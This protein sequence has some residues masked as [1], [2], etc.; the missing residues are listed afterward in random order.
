[1]ST[2]VKAII[3]NS[4]IVSA[5]ESKAIVNRA[6]KIH[7]LSPIATVAVGRALTMAA[8]MGKELKNECDYLT[9]VIDG[10]GPLGKI[11]VCA[12]ASGHVKCDV[13]NPSLESIFKFDGTLDVG[14]AVGKSG[15]LTV[16]KD[17]GLKQP[18]VG[19]AK[20]VSG[21][22]ASD[23][24]YY[25]AASEQQ[26]CGITLGVGLTNKQRCK[27]AGG[28]FVQIMPNCPQEL[29][30]R[31]ETI[32]Y[33]MDEMSYQFDGSSAEDV[34]RR[35][36]GEFDLVFSERTK[37]SYK[38]NCGK[39]KIDRVVKSLGK[40]EA[41]AIIDEQG[42]IEVCCHFCGKRYSYDQQAIDKLFKKSEFNS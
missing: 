41:Q 5:V 14:A 36:F 10:G 4:I 12:D 37:V 25:Y 9:A 28:V 11:T 38:C 20:L 42:Q 1:M 7:N 23:F 15:A 24:A 6:V 35:F 32:M 30:S 21:E 17:I 22:I 19:T 13:I 27:S 34:V 2:L 29:L 40:S 33:A 8:L 26:P 16:I 3:N 39:R 31:V 18:Y